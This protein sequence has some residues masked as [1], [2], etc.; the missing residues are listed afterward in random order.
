MDWKEIR[1][2]L[3]DSGDKRVM[4][5][6]HRGKFSSNVMEN[7]SLAF[8]LALEEGADMVEMDLAMTRDGKL[9]AHHDDTM[10]RL[11]HVKGT[12]ADYSLNELKE[13]E[14]YNYIGEVCE[15]KIESFEDILKELKGRTLL[16]L[17]KCWDCWD[18]VHRLL[19]EWD[20]VEQAVF[21]FYIEDDRALSWAYRHPEC[22]F[23]PMLK[24]T[25]DLERVFSLK[26]ASQLPALEILPKKIS[27]A[28]FQKETFDLLDKNHIKVWCNS[29]SLGKRLVYGA[30]H[31]D[32]KSL[33]YG[34]DAGWRHL[35][36]RGVGIIQT[37]WPYEL[38]RYMERT[39][40][41]TGEPER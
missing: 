19:M 21:K 31:D 41:G 3:C 5:A 39:G 15:E 27:D 6:S 30:G 35:I 37:D 23:I 4:I 7:T 28:V 8:H 34:G 14:L 32:L 33:R 13:M 11:F 1:D 9:A 17:D 38:K 10:E 2:R 22:M 36:E 26:S 40:L 18:E 12:I 25:A 16:V 29:L 24:D 20:M